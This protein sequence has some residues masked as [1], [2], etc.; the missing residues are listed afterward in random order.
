MPARSLRGAPTPAAPVEI[1]IKLAFP[2]ASAARA[3][4]RR[5]GFRVVE[6]RAL[7]TNALFDTPKGTLRAKDLVVRLRTYGKKAILTYKGRAE[8]RAGDH[9]KQRIELE[10]QVS[11]PNPVAVILSAAGLQPRFYYEKYRTVFSPS[12][13]T[14]HAMLDE[15]PI[16]IYVE[17]EG[18]PAWIDRIASS[19]GRTVSDY[20]HTS[21][22]AL[23]ANKCKKERR[24][25]GDMRFALDGT[26]AK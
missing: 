11:D 6:R 3:A 23:H 4:L 26:S 13:G 22:P 8:G 24:P 18:P 1:E 17:L 9:H 5:L 12:D 21:Y 10:S 2:S 19:L 14:G 15:T 20:I 25:I 7:E 16:G